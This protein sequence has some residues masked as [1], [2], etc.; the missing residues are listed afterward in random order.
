MDSIWQTKRWRFISWVKSLT[1]EITKTWVCSHWLHGL[2]VLHS[3]YPSPHAPAL[4]QVLG[5]VRRRKQAGQW[6]Q[7]AVALVSSHL[8]LLFLFTDAQYILYADTLGTYLDACIWS[9]S[10]GEDHSEVF[11]S[12]TSHLSSAFIYIMDS[13]TCTFKLGIHGICISPLWAQLRLTSHS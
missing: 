6:Q 7:V 2:Y 13:R 9:Y 11:T 5:K 8:T 10:Q 12:M 3:R 4:T 1:S